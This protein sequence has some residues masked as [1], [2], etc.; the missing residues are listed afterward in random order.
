M[1]ETNKPLVIEIDLNKK[2]K[3]CGLGAIGALKNGLCIRC[4]GDMVI[5]KM[6]QESNKGEK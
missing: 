6:K 4:H 5:E 2:C 1:S 3:K